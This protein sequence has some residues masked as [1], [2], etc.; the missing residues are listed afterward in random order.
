M[1]QFPLTQKESGVNR[2]VGFQPEQEE[3][4][5]Q[6]F[7]NKFETKTTDTKEKEKTSEQQDIIERINSEM[8]DFLAQ[9]GVEAIEVSPDNVHILDKT[10]FTDVELK[11]I[12]EQFGTENG[13]YSALKQGVAIMK[14]YNT[15]KLSFLQTLVHETLHLQGFY[16]YQKSLQ[17]N[18]DLTLKNKDDLASI[19]IRR[20]GFSIGTTDG[21]RLL[22]H[23]LNESVITELEIRFE[24]T[25][26]TRW[27]ELEEELR[28]RDEYI[29]KIAERD[30]IPI[31]KVEQIVAGITGDKSTG[32]KWVSYPYHEERQQFN[33]LIDELY[34]KNKNNFESREQV[35][36]LF[37]NATL[38]GRLLPITRLVEK[39]FGK[40]SFRMLGE[41]SADK[42]K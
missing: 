1:E 15:S 6:Y 26:M 19:N 38:T 32:H 14:D 10:K 9:H 23:K 5:L 11:K 3:E 40:G 25:H 7:K 12:Y 22:F 20:S 36:N 17:E 4:F 8:K 31:E 39:N 30:C 37:V 18:A 2:I 13:F 42:P 27:P 33:S 35:F 34:E 24:K 16:S 28:N 21:K 29:K 41:R